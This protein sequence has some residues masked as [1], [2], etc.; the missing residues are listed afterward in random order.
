MSAAVVRPLPV[1]RA[2]AA[3]RV[4]DHPATDSPYVG[5][6]YAYPHKT[7]YRPMPPRPLADVWAGEDRSAAFLYLHVPFCEMRCGF[8]NLFTQANP[9]ASFERDY[10]DAARRQINVVADAVGPTKV[11]RVAVGGGTPTYLDAA[12]LDDVL[13]HLRSRFAVGRVPTSVETS[14]AT[15]TADRLRVLRDHGTTRVSMGVQSLRDDEVR[16]AR[17]IQTTRQVAGAVERMHA[18]GFETINL[19]LIYGLPGQTVQSWLA[20]VEAALELGPT[21]LFLYPL[22]VRE[23][24]GLGRRG[25]DSHDDLR[26][27][28]YRAGRDLLRSRGFGQFSMR[29]F[30]RADAPPVDGPAYCCQRDGMIGLGCGARSY[31]RSLHYADDWATG[32]AGV[33]EILRD[34]AG[35]T[36]G[37]FARVDYGCE[38]DG[39]EQRRRWAIQSLL[40][41]DGL[42]RVVYR[43]R[44]GGDVLD[45]LPQLRALGELA[46]IGDDLIRL[47]D[48][49]TERSDA[50]GPWLYSP[51]VV[52]AMNDFDLR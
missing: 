44:F 27:A 38:L 30:R 1:R 46:T 7:A 28:C 10:L 29:M 36:D 18:L 48:A 19:D 43:D 15:A 45:D 20:S 34:F 49:G 6:S 17:R 33:R 16:A 24:T 4:P 41:A 32:A 50:I 8:C 37:Q 35:R 40:N 14:P 23:L 12:T 52:A 31:A 47:T 9:A 3:P 5:Y 22:Y 26:L 25:A 13:G 2:P 42:C 21:E 51:A 39:G 11:A